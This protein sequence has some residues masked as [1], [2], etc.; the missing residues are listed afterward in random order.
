MRSVEGET[1]R[2]LVVKVVPVAVESTSRD[3]DLSFGTTK[4]RWFTVRTQS[5]RPTEPATQVLTPD[6][7]VMEIENE[8]TDTH[9]VKPASNDIQSSALLGDEHHRLALVDGMHDE[10]G[11]R[12]GLAGAGRTLNHHRAAR[13]GGGNDLGLGGIG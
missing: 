12:L 11:D 6:L 2:V 7:R 13:G 9:G 8:I 10:I 3:G 5:E 4:V 1:R